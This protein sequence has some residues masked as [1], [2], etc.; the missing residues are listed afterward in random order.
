MF[1]VDS[2]VQV[3]ASQL[4]GHLRP[5]PVPLAAEKS[6]L[7]SEEN[8][9]CSKGLTTHLT[10]LQIVLDSAYDSTAPVRPS[11]Y[12]QSCQHPFPSSTLQEL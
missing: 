6:S 1:T 7:M 9:S 5:M 8:R 4:E 3:D 2:D 11:R 10:Q 12:Q